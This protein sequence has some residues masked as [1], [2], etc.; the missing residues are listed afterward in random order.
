MKR[1]KVEIVLGFS[2]LVVSWL[3]GGLVRGQPAGAS[4]AEAVLVVDGLVREIFTSRRQDRLDYLVLIE[5][6]RSEA[7]RTPRERVRFVMPAPGDVVYVHVSDRMDAAIGLP[8]GRNPVT[9]ADARPLIVPAEGSQVTAYL[10]PRQ[11]G[12]WEAI[13][14]PWFAST[15]GEAAAPGPPSRR[16]ETTSGAPIPS[17]AAPGPASPAAAL[18]LLGLSAEPLNAQGRFALRVTG[19][20]RGR[21]AERAGIELGDVIVGANDRPLSGIDQLDD[22]VR[23]GGMLKL[24]VLDINTGKAAR[25]SV[26]LGE[27]PRAGAS[28]PVAPSPPTAGQAP[29]GAKRSLGISAEPVALGQRTALKVVAVV[30]G[31]PAQKAGIEPGD[32][33]VSA[34]GAPVTAIEQFGAALRKSGPTLSLVIR[35]TRSGRDVPVEVQLGGPASSTPVTVPDEPPARA[36]AARGLGAVTE[37]F[38]YDADPA[39]KV[40]EVERGSPAARAGLK[41]GDVILQAN[42]TPILHPNTLNEIV[43][44]SGSVLK[45]VVVDPTTRTRANVDVDLS[46][47]R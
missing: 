18:R 29:S 46:A 37:L 12:G 6:K 30:P 43:G 41:P 24:V 38:F 14:P 8:G 22:L 44:K 36:G 35:D 2:T 23:K 39:V 32:V 45:L 34:N 42:G 21:P 19:V 11:S 27:P 33:I 10:V 20:E 47:V 28:P 40:S 9:G 5:V 31:S 1:R 4:K 7:G 13:T 3:A 17:E 15:A 16:S 25:V 26:E